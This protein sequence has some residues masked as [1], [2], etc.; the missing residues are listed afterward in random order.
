MRPIRNFTRPR[1]SASVLGGSVIAN[2][3]TS[4]IV[5]TVVC[6]QNTRRHRARTAGNRPP[7]EVATPEPAGVQ[8]RAETDQIRMSRIRT[9]VS[10]CVRLA[11]SIWT[12]CRAERLRSR[13]RL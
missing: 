12:S 1:T 13:S 10:P 9:S 3:R 5:T 4:A 2:A 8:V 6:G 11:S 7:P